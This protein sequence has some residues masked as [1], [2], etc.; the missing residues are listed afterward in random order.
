MYQYI[1]KLKSKPDHVKKSILL[2]AL[3][4]SMSLVSIVWFY[5][6]EDRFDSKKVTEKS[7]EDVKPFSLLIDSISN[8]VKNISASV[9]S[10]PSIKDKINQN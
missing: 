4:F 2:F 8:T 10:A 3:I 6:L 5:N 1:K 7:R 9:G